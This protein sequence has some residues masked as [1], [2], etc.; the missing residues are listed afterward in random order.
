MDRLEC[1]DLLM[2]AYFSSLTQQGINTS[3]LEN[4]YSAQRAEIITKEK[5]DIK[6]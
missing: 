3:K 5:K 6:K 4:I 1:N 2:T